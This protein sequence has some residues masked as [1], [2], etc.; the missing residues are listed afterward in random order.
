MNLVVPT[1]IMGVVMAILLAIGYL[2]GGGQHISGTKEGLWMIVEIAPLLLFA[3]VI[4]GM[5][6]ELLP[7]ETVATWVGEESGMR[8][9]IIGTLTGAI[10]PGGPFV[11]MP[12]A[13]GLL[14]AGASMGTMVAF[15]TAW[16]I[17]AVARMPLELGIMG[18]K[19]TLIRLAC[20]FFLPPVAGILANIFFSGV[21]P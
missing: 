20:S 11:S 18:W 4:A 1:I 12:I 13:A 8:G 5:V 9:I 6:R 7:H 15:L 2:K 14:R 19:F 3:F 21:K 10:T 16:S 17:L